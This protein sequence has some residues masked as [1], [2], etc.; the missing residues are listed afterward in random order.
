[1]PSACTSSGRAS[2]P[3]PGADTRPRRRGRTGRRRSRGRSARR[4]RGPRRPA[5][6]RRRR[7]ARRGRAGSGAPSTGSTGRPASVASRPAKNARA[8]RL[9]SVDAQET[10]GP[11]RTSPKPG[12]RAIGDPMV[13]QPAREPRDQAV[14]TA[15]ARQR[16][17]LQR[18]QPHP[19]LVAG[20]QRPGA[21]GRPR[22]RRS[23]PA[24][25][26]SA[27]S[28]GRR[29]AARRR[30]RGRRTAARAVAVTA[31][32]YVQAR[33]RIWSP[34]RV[35]GGRVIG[36][37]EPRGRVTPRSWPPARDD[38]AVVAT[39]AR[40]THAKTSAA[41]ILSSSS[42]AP[43]GQNPQR[44]RWTDIRVGAPMT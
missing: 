16:A 8:S 38:F 30:R 31:E 2:S 26:R 32:S 35:A 20:S 14:V 9:C 5:S 39:T 21:I 24:R 41:R 1:M 27:G 25:R 6:A 22:G 15:R 19:G 10:S 28:P 43:V 42:A 12:E 23:L 29:P 3:V 17:P 11:P 34:S 13:E 36:L 18:R 40:R 33:P 7:R 44:V 37:H 4:R